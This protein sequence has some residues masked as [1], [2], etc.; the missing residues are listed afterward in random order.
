MKLSQFLFNLVEAC[1]GIDQR[2]YHPIAGHWHFTKRA[3][4]FAGRKRTVCLICLGGA[5]VAAK[6]DIPHTETVQPHNFPEGYDVPHLM[7]EEMRAIDEIRSGNYHVACKL[8]DIEPPP[9]SAY[10]CPRESD[11]KEFEGWTEF[12][13]FL[14]HLKKHAIH[15]Q[16]KGH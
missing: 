8:L 5:W 14:L 16:Q 15:F 2:N 7:S 4:D 6:T 10:P 11:F 3:K 9:Y 12:R 1:N 13:L